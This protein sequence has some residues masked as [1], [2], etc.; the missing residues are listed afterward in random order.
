M[1]DETCITCGVKF[2]IE[3]EYARCIRSSG[4]VP[5]CPNGHSYTYMLSDERDRLRKT[6]E[7]RESSI[8]MLRQQ[9]VRA[10]HRIAALK[11]VIRKMKKK[12][13]LSK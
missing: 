3:Y 9:S 7:T 13:E 8:A 12:A 2:G 5:H 4:R 10:E 1:T 11:G 6:I